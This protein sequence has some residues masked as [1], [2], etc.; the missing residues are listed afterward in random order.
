MAG[1]QAKVLSEAQQKKVLAYIENF[2]R[3][4]LRNRVMF[5]LSVKAGL[6]AIEI[7]KLCWTHI[8]D[9][10]GGLSDA[11]TFEDAASKGGKGGRTIPINARLGEAL[12][13]LYAETYPEPHQP[14][15]RTERAKLGVSRQVIV[16]QFAKWFKGAGLEGCS[17][18]SGRRTFI[19]NAARKISTVGGSLRDV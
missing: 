12:A 8:L 13:E 16:N 1:K 6:R 18:H 4:P 17:S 3:Y 9:A 15:I 10:D 19:T 11:I 5:L 14:V 2:T 7:S